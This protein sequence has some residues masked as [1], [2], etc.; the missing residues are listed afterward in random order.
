MTDE[1]LWNA[2]EALWRYVCWPDGHSRIAPIPP[3]H[4]GLIGRP[5]CLHHNSLI[6]T[7]LPPYFRVRVQ[8]RAALTTATTL[9]QQY[10]TQLPLPVSPLHY[11][12]YYLWSQ[13]L[14]VSFPCHPVWDSA[15]V[16][17]R[18][19]RWLP[20]TAFLGRTDNPAPRH[21]WIHWHQAYW[22]RKAKEYD[23]SVFAEYFP[24]PPSPSAA[25]RYTL[26]QQT[27][28]FHTLA[29][30]HHLE[31]GL[32]I[33]LHFDSA[34]I[35]KTEGFSAH[36][37]RPEILAARPE[38]WR[39]PGYWKLPAHEDLRQYVRLLAT[40]PRKWLFQFLNHTIPLLNPQ[41]YLQATT[42]RHIYVDIAN[43]FDDCLTAHGERSLVRKFAMERRPAFIEAA[44]RIVHETR[45]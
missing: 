20:I 39:P 11:A 2:Y 9:L 13:L 1:I 44:E 41:T 31:D 4:P 22:V 37:W 3:S 5:A 10:Q 38:T 30:S 34:G 24:L 23:L 40:G 27:R 42:R 29:L 19:L 14:R 25:A 26:S 45:E 43:G 21:A 6:P 16:G 33:F 18:N 32:D 35:P 15:S 8:S 12:Y 28:T 7:R 17:W 36:A